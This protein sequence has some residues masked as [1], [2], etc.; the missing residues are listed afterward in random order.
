MSLSKIASSLGAS[1]RD[2]TLHPEH[3][4]GWFNSEF[5]CPL[6]IIIQQLKTGQSCWRLS[7]KLGWKLNLPDTKLTQ[8]NL[9]SCIYTAKQDFILRKL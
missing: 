2:A 9:G 4:C 5:E 3:T 1:K 8:R 6:R 7:T